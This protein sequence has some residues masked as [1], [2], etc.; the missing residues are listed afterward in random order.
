MIGKFKLKCYNMNVVNFDFNYRGDFKMMK[1]EDIIEQNLGK[2][3]VEFLTSLAFKPIRFKINA[4]IKQ[5]TKRWWLIPSAFMEYGKMPLVFLLA[6]LKKRGDV[7]IKA[8]EKVKDEVLLTLALAE[9]VDSTARGIRKAGKD[10]GLDY[11][12]ARDR[13][14]LSN[15]MMDSL[16]LKYRELKKD[17]KLVE[18]LTKG[19]KVE[20]DKDSEF[21][22]EFQGDD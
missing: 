7:R 8:N 20:W 17:G 18:L 1:L 2:E 13:E 6:W 16:F 9:V 14:I 10:F 3:K 22:V 21:M 5:N 4:F 15:A 11:N 12:K 19:W